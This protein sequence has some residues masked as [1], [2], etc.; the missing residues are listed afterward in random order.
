VYAQAVAGSRA[1]LDEDLE[2]AAIEHLL[3]SEEQ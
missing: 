1:D 2:A 3:E